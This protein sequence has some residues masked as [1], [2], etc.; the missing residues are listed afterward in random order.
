MTA[1]SQSEKNEKGRASGRFIYRADATDF[2]LRNYQAG[3]VAN[4]EKTLA[5]QSDCSKG[6]DSF[7]ALAWERRQQEYLTQGNMS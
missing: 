4:I 3:G 1:L 6:V 5:D 7:R 2:E